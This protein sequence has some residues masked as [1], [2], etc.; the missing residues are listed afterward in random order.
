[1]RRTLEY[2]NLLNNLNFFISILVILPIL[3]VISSLLLLFFDN[4]LQFKN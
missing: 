3:P 4:I 2:I 1:M